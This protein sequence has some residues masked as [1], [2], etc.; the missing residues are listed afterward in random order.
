MQHYHLF[1]VPTF[2][3]SELKEKKYIAKPQIENGTHYI[4]VTIG[5]RQIRTKM[6][7]KYDMDTYAQFGIDLGGLV[8]YLKRDMEVR[9]RGEFRA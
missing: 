5:D 7:T 6:N 8:F 3:I 2:D 4:I 9:W 1:S